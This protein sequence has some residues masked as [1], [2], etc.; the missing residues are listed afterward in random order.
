MKT[1][2]EHIT[3]ESSK[4]FSSAEKN[5]C[6][7]SNESITVVGLDDYV[8]I[9]E[10]AKKYRVTPKTIRNWISKFGDVPRFNS[11]RNFTFR[12]FNTWYVLNMLPV[13]A[14]KYVTD[15]NFPTESIPKQKRRLRLATV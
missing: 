9:E 2:T 15:F 14:R 12:S 7:K 10:I 5:D 11:G 8:G 3:N 6:Q 1:K 13:E 4:A